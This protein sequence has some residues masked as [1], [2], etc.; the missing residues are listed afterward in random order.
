MPVDKK[1][2]RFVA[3]ILSEGDAESKRLNA[4]ISEKQSQYM[5]TAENEILAEV[6]AHIR[7]RSNQIKIEAGRKISKHAF[8]SK[9]L[10][11]Q[12]RSEIAEEVFEEVRQR[13]CV[14]V[15]SPEYPGILLQIAKRAKAGLKCDNDITILLRK[16]DMKYA[17]MLK[18]E[19]GGQYKEGDI[20][21]GGLIAY[22]EANSMLVDLTYDAA[23]GTMTENFAMISDF[24][25]D[26]L[27]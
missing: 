24:G 9:R 3:A 19:V 10:L 18:N 2:E 5:E 14:Y 11:H 23:M 22:S 12:R 7:S 21:Y 13:V 4:E 27:S 16:E 25:S 20:K 26:G 17:E 15:S 1:L 8:N 6:Y